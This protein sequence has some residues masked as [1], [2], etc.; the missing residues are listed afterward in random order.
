M[1][2]NG[3]TFND[4]LRRQ[5]NR[6]KAFGVENTVTIKGK[7]NIGLNGMGLQVAIPS[8]VDDDA[9]LD[10]FKGYKWIYCTEWKNSQVPIGDTVIQFH[11][12][13]EVVQG[14]FQMSGM[15]A[16]LGLD[17]YLS[18]C[19]LNIEGFDEQAYITYTLDVETQTEEIGWLNSGSRMRYGTMTYR[20]EKIDLSEISAILLKDGE[21]VGLASNEI[22]D[23]GLANRKYRADRGIWIG[24]DSALAMDKI[25]KLT[26]M[27]GEPKKHLEVNRDMWLF[28]VTEDNKLELIR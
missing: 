2:Q 13:Y 11:S 24:R 3:V 27:L 5:C 7:I 17:N 28:K 1:T 16:S 10:W 22:I 14:W 8:I 19:I 20:D 25:N 9:R 21:H 4:Y 15:L 6:L 12:H 23:A 18:K 26:G